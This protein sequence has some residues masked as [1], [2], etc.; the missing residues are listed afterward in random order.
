[1]ARK[2][3]F[4]LLL[5]YTTQLFATHLIGGII[6]YK[7]IDNKT[8]EVT[9]KM[10][11]DCGSN[12]T[13][14][15]G[16]DSHINIA[17]FDKDWNL[18]DT[19]SIY[20][21]FV[22]KLSPRGPTPCLQTPAEICL[23]E[24]VYKKTV[25]LSID[26][27]KHY[28]VHQ[29]CCR[30]ASTLNVATTNSGVGTTYVTCIP[31]NNSVICNNTPD[32]KEIPLVLCA[33]YDYTF[34][35]AASDADNDSLVYS[36]ET[37]LNGGSY[38]TPIPL[39]PNRGPYL[40]IRW[41]G[42][43]SQNNPM[44]GNPGITIDPI[45]GV[46]TGHPTRLGIYAVAIGITEYRNNVMINKTVHEVNITV[47]DCAPNVSAG[48]QDQ[49]DVGGS[50]TYCQG[51][52]I[53]FK[54]TTTNGTTYF[55]DFGDSSTADDTS[56]LETPTFNYS[57]TG[58][59]DVTLIVNPGWP[60]A[61]TITKPFRVYPKII[62]YFASQDTACFDNHE[63]NLTAEGTYGNNAIF[64]WDNGAGVTSTGKDV[65]VSYSEPGSYNI[66]LS[67]HENGCTETYIDRVHV[68]PNPKAKFNQDTTQGCTPLTVNFQNNSTAV[69]PLQY[70]WN[71]GDNTNSTAHSPSK[72]F[73]KQGNYSVG[74]I[75]ST[76]N[77]CIDT[78]TTYYNF[79]NA[80]PVPTAN[81]TRTPAR[82]SILNP[83]ISVT[84]LVNPDE[85]DSLR[86]FFEDGTE[87]TN[88]NYEHAFTSSGR[89]F[90]KQ[91]VYSKTHGCTDTL[92]KTVYLEPSYAF[93]VPNTF[94][95]NGDGIND[96]LIA[97]ISDFQTIEFQIFDRWGQLIFETNQPKVE[98]NG[99]VSD[100]NKA[101]SE[102]YLYRAKIKDVKNRTHY[103][104][105]RIN[106]L[107]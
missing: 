59:Y 89:Q 21:P 82:E 65:A 33:N 35:Y 80:F 47:V 94:T 8:Y 32:L 25:T 54:N 5:N 4:I 90:I 16:F 75:V 63:F 58:V 102:T 69:T 27:G 46:I 51:N 23:E 71:F 85:I 24:G 2:L 17:V 3:L 6:S 38:R 92:T 84:N 44:N 95:P 22:K 103:E 45:T 18:V 15:T 26:D 86:Y 77:G 91:V 98:W 93:Y 101:P 83:Y 96:V 62:P 28:L 10:Y 60:C 30:T 39:P 76:A 57:D 67:I 40:K 50:N 64:S 79:I 100:G 43:F 14:N 68:Y 36:L 81:F 9:L 7:C 73:E 72:T 97:Q 99:E 11:R 42:G 88:Y 12:N 105:G 56:N 13:I 37:P 107:R 70:I 20:D 53:E 29:R 49:T 78:D 87:T 31:E 74:L 41:G 1:M 61:D 104:S 34:D 66:A 19:F 48:I 52:T 55:W 106:I